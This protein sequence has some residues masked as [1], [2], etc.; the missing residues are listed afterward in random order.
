M[1][2]DITG[3]WWRRSRISILSTSTTS[4]RQVSRIYSAVSDMNE[5][6]EGTRTSP[7]Q[8]T[9]LHRPSTASTGGLALR[10]LLEEINFHLSQSLEGSP[11]VIVWGTGQLTMKLLCETVLGSHPIAAFVDSNPINQ[12]K[13]IH[14]VRV[15]SPL[16]LQRSGRM[17]PIVIGS[18]LHG[19]DIIAGIR[20]RYR[21]ANALIEL[22]PAVTSAH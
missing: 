21:L 19:Q 22:R 2:P 10:R 13:V 5:G 12:G 16:E 7:A 3:F 8:R 17:E 15:L 18:L 14:G 4:L 6:M 20:E 1:P 9:A 11:A